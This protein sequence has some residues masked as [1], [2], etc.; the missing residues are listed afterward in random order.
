MKVRVTRKELEANG[1]CTL[2][3]IVNDLRE[4]L[5][6]SVAC[7][8]LSE[9]ANI[10]ERLCIPQLIIDNKP[11]YHVSDVRRMVI[12]CRYTPFFRISPKQEKRIFEYLKRKENGTK[13]QYPTH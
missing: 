12:H 6:N 10:R 11:Y 5:N 2:V 8:L 3:Q 1:Y 7:C 4:E 9:L 13:K